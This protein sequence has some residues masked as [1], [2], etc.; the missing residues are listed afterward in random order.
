M[1]EAGHANRLCFRAGFRVLQIGNKWMARAAGPERW[2]V[3]ISLSESQHQGWAAGEFV[4][5]SRAMI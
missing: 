1:P 2:R 5:F 3:L 4:I